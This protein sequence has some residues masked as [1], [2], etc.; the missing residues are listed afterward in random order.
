MR[1]ARR[2]GPARAPSTGRAL[3]AIVAHGTPISKREFGR[4]G[5]RRGEGMR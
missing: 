5:L 2:T 3:S 4:A 1:G